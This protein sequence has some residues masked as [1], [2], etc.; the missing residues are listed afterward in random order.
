[1]GP[2]EYEFSLLSAEWADREFG[3]GWEELSTDIESRRYVGED[4]IIGGY[5][6][7]ELY[8]PL[9]WYPGIGYRYFA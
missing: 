7:D 6:P 4:D 9:L 3:I 2:E 1:M 8:N 5:V